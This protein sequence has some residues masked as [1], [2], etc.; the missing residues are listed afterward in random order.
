MNQ[1]GLSQVLMGILKQLGSI[2]YHRSEVFYV[3]HNMI[4]TRA[5]LKWPGIVQ[6][7]AIVCEHKA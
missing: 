3:I 2:F 1:K 4:L 5:K 7:Y 6:R